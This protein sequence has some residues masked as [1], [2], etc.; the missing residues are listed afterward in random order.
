M[1][2]KEKKDT[3]RLMH[4]VFSFVYLWTKYILL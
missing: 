3:G 2:I 4:N 1:K